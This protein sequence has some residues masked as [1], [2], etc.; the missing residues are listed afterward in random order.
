MTGLPLKAAI[1]VG[2]VCYLQVESWTSV[3]SWLSYLEHLEPTI[4]LL[5]CNSCTDTDSKL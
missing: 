2:Y 5:V 3:N 1:P 4:K